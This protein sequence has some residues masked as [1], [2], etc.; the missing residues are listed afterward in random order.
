[1]TARTGPPGVGRWSQQMQT[2]MEVMNDG[3]DWYGAQL[4]T[5]CQ[6]PP[7]VIYPILTRLTRLGILSVR[8]EDVDTRVV[9]RPRRRYYRRVRLT[10]REQANRSK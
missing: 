1:V 8:W 4:S 2:V 10:P 6:I 5:T 9:G 7:G 3:Q